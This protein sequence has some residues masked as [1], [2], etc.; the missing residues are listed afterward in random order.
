[1][2]PATW[3]TRSAQS[4]MQAL[5][6]RAEHCRPKM[7]LK[8]N[9]PPSWSGLEIHSRPRAQPTFSPRCRARVHR[10]WRAISLH[11][12][13]ASAKPSDWVEDRPRS[14]V[15][16]VRS[17]A[18]AKDSAYHEGACRGRCERGVELR[19]LQ[20]G[21]GWADYTSGTAGHGGRC[22]RLG[23]LSGDQT[24]PYLLSVVPA[25]PV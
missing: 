13:W 12:L 17:G 6:P 4:M 20:R 22:D 25:G 14:W 1:M 9:S 10:W 18:R 5:T 2:P 3:T 15:Q 16:H 24:A 7:V 19:P 23:D 11:D 21:W 8:R